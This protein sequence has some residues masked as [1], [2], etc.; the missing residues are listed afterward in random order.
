MEPYN[1]E[2][3]EDLLGQFYDPAQA[4]QIADNIRKGERILRANPAPEP[5]QSLIAEIKAKAARKLQ[6]R[7]TTARRSALVRAAAI[8]AIFVLLAWPA[9]RYFKPAGLTDKTRTPP[10]A[11]ISHQIWESTDIIEDDPDL[12]SLNRGLEDIS[13]SLL[14]ARLD[15]QAHSNGRAVADIEADLIEIETDFWK[16]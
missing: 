5:S 14:S 7:Q 4:K 11:M 2:N 1:N 13:K 12:A 10:V 15:E 16:G 3:F 6:Q 9:A 8:A